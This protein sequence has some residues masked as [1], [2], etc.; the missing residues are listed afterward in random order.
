MARAGRRTPSRGG[1]PG[2]DEATLRTT[3]RTRS[4]RRC[5]GTTST[6]TRAAAW[7]ARSCA[8]ST[9]ARPRSRGG[10]RGRRGWSPGRWRAVPRAAAT[11]TCPGRRWRRPSGPRSGTSSWSG[12]GSPRAGRRGGRGRGG[13]G[14]PRRARPGRGGAGGRGRDG[15][16]TASEG[17]GAG[18]PAALPARRRTKARAA[19]DAA[20]EAACR[21]IAAGGDAVADREPAQ[22]ART[23]VLEAGDGRRE[24]ARAKNARSAESHNVW[25]IAADWTEAFA[26][27]CSSR[28]S[29]AA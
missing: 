11:P 22:A 5:P 25:H 16:D 9:T 19:D 1:P 21:P 2:S 6:A 15:G 26:R 7:S 23:V 8:A 12:P 4:P 28:S 24:A 18:R 29:A 20:G 14:R 13:R 17:G 10:T 27:W 3:R